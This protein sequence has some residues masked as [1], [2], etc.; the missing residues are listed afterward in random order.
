M[1]QNSE[2][3]RSSE[4]EIISPERDQLRASRHLVSTC[5]I[6][7]Y[8]AW[9]KVEEAEGLKLES[10][11]NLLA[12]I[13]NGLKSLDTDLH[14]GDIVQLLPDGFDQENK[15]GKESQ[16]Y[17]G[18]RH[19]NNW[20]VFYDGT[21]LQMLQSNF[22]D[23]GHIPDSCTVPNEFPTGYWIH[24]IDYHREVEF[25]DRDLVE[26][27]QRTDPRV[28]EISIRQKIEENESVYPYWKVIVNKSNE[29]VTYSET[30][31]CDDK[32]QCEE[33]YVIGMIDGFDTPYDEEHHL[34][35][36]REWSK[37][38]H[39]EDTGDGTQRKVVYA[40]ENSWDDGITPQGKAVYIG[41]GTISS[42]MSIG[43]VKTIQYK[44]GTTKIECDRAPLY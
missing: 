14:R 13:L 16:F 40:G 15:F 37:V 30:C 29:G 8:D 22:G 2:I 3:S 39:L 26:Y 33:F 21:H 44:N 43:G 18:R 24:A 34:E 27:I 32:C 19:R 11:R 7:C 10:L 36:L 5:Y 4:I 25:L 9:Y 12:K 23:E 31:E 6:D 35:L 42:V 28:G 38:E 17:D 1:A 41:V 20:L